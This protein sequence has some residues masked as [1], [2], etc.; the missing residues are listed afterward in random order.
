MNLLYRSSSKDIMLICMNEQWGLQ[1][2]Y[3]PPARDATLKN[4]NIASV[5]WYSIC[6]AVP[7][8]DE[9]YYHLMSSTIIWWAV[10]SSGEQYHHLMSS[11]IIRWALSS[12]DEQYHHLMSST[13]IWWA[14]SSSDEQYYHLM[15]ILSSDEF[16]QHIKLF[17]V[18]WRYN[19][20]F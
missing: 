14:L 15:S 6:W 13:I 7:S 1:L 16:K 3:D 5:T 17:D 10:L 11:T 12:S 20:L 18:C 4:H 19:T 8:S 9:Q 2:I